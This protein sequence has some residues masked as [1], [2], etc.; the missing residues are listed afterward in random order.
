M[1]VVGE[2][3]TG[4]ST[5][6]K[7]LSGLENPDL[8]EVASHGTIAFVGQDMAMN[9]HQTV[10]DLIKLST[11]H[12]HTALAHLD[13]A[14]ELLAL[15]HAGA[16]AAYAQALEKAS[17]LEAWDIDRKIDQALHGLKA[18]TDRSRNLSTLSVGQRYRVRLAVLLGAGADVLL[19]DE[20]TNHLDRESIEFLTQSL[21]ELKSGF[22]VVS[23]D[24]QHQN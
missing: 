22:A 1:A 4:K 20:P 24:R 9:D 15:G 21:Q 3:G 6:L 5:L 16:E 2:N 17:A 19:L 10:G 23:H 11:Q 8:G 12:A 14:S 13:R 7:I 18:C